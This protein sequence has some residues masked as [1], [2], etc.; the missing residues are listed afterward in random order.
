[1]K[2]SIEIEFD[3]PGEEPRD[4]SIGDP[5]RA[6]MDPAEAI[7][8]LEAAITALRSG[9]RTKIANAQHMV[10]D[11]DLIGIEIIDILED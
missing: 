4:M 11:V 10:A 2:M 7:D 1:M 3:L 6:A 9:D 5:G 8:A